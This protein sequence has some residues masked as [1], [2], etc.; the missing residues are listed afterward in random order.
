MYVIRSG[1]VKG[2]MKYEV[3]VVLVTISYQYHN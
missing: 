1:V 2:G 3:I